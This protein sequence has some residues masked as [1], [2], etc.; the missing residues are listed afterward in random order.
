MF[1]VSIYEIEHNEDVHLPE[2]FSLGDVAHCLVACRS[3]S[4]THRLVAAQGWEKF[5]GLSRRSF[6]TRNGAPAHI[7]KGCTSA[8]SIRGQ[9]TPAPRFLCPLACRETTHWILENHVESWLISVTRLPT[10]V[11]PV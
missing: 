6:L 9:L 5:V 10:R 2:G 4:P 7:I 1:R 8:N 3:P 11:Q